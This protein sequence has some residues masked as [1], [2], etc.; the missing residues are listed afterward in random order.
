MLISIKNINN[1]YIFNLKYC[2]TSVFHQYV[3]L[4]KRKKLIQIF[5]I[6][7]GIHYP[8]AIHQLNAFKK[9]LKKDLNAEQLASNSISLPIDP[10]LSKK[11]VLKICEVVN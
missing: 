6:S 8:R 7:F 4:T 3:I 9:Y 10:N 11:N 2:K 5:K 1:K